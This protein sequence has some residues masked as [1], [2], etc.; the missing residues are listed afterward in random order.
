MNFMN[1]NITKLNNGDFKVE[2]M[3]KCI[4]CNVET[5]VPQSLHVD[6]RNHYIDGAGQLCHECFSEI[7][8]HCELT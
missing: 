2:P 1:S 5:N 6:Y 4:V 3:E 8:E 7:D